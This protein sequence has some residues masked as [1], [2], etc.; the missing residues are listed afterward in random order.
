MRELTPQERRIVE[1]IA[2][3]L[4]T[5]RIA[6]ELGVGR[7]SVR[8]HIRVMRDRYGVDTMLGLPAATGEDRRLRARRDS[9]RT[10]E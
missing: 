2:D 8:R 10:R 7:Y 4:D 6:D 3:G 9:E 5:Q 1:L